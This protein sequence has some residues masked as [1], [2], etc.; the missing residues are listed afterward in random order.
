MRSSAIRACVNALTSEFDVEINEKKLI[1]AA[2][3]Q[4]QPPQQQAELYIVV[5]SHSWERM[6]ITGVDIADPQ[7][8]EY[9]LGLSVTVSKRIQDISRDRLN[10]LL[11]PGENTESLDECLHR[12]I[13]I[14]HG[15]YDIVNEANDY[16]SIGSFS[17]PPFFADADPEPEYVDE[18]WFGNDSRMPGQ[19]IVGAQQT[20]RFEGL[21]YQIITPCN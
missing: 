18:G 15:S 3:P 6:G 19:E 2:R 9:S 21:H 10:E 4:G 14:L 8:V 7:V 12:C 20:A 1:V 16:S 11:L 17:T 5:H 13:A